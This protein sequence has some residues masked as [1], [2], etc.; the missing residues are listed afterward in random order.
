MNERMYQVAIYQ[1][2][3][4]QFPLIIP[5]R[6]SL[7]RQAITCSNYDRVCGLKSDCR[8]PLDMCAN[9]AIGIWG[10]CQNPNTETNSKVI[11]IIHNTKIESFW[12]CIQNA[13]SG[14]NSNH[15]Q[16]LTFSTV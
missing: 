5:M 15:V 11:D 3:G 12:T 14:G 8:R 6:S 4:S 10:I 7:I 2:L 9:Q 13:Q 1:V 16:C